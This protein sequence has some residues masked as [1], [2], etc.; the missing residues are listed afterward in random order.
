M[1]HRDGTE[2][3][4]RN[5]RILA[6]R[7]LQKIP[8][9]RGRDFTQEATSNRSTNAS[10]CEDC[11]GMQRVGDWPI[12]KGDPSKHTPV[13]VHE[14]FQAY[15]DYGLGQVITSASERAAVAKSA[16]LVER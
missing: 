11:G 5:E 12:C 6:E 14:P 8:S 7:S 16:G 13:P 2:T 9:A 4:S 10:L 1:L 3:M 15:F